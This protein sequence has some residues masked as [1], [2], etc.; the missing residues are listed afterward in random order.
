M[1]ASEVSS[2]QGQGALALT[3]YEE[4]LWYVDH[5]TLILLSHV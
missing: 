1:A 2:S 4:T 3:S 5:Q